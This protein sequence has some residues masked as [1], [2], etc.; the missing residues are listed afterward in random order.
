M[1]ILLDNLTAVLI[2]GT[3]FL[4]AVFVF[5]SDREA[6]AEATAFYAM[7]RHQEDFA[8]IVTND[9]QGVSEV[10][11]TEI[12][13]D[14]WFAF[15]GFIGDDATPYEIAYQRELVAERDGIIYYR[16]RRHTRPVGDPTW[17]EEG[18]SSDVITDW[19]I[20]GRDEFGATAGT[21]AAV[22][23]VYVHFKVGSRL[24]PSNRLAL[25]E[26]ARVDHTMWE[27]SFFPPLLQ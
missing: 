5:Q 15:R 18:G 17:T 8:K 4:M 13:P 10:L 1:H 2:G 3:I 14:G 11:V 24:R 23:Q 20:E 22:A 16:I 9:L 21:P 25:G 27:A 19:V 6:L 26:T 7:I 12:D